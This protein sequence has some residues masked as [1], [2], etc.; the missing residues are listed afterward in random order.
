MRRELGV[1]GGRGTIWARTVRGQRFN[2]RGRIQRFF[3]AAAPRHAREVGEME[4]SGSCG[5]CVGPA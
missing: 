5:W 4:A 2:G 1:P 3:A